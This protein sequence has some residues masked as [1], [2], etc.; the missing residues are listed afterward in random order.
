[1]IDGSGDVVTETASSYDLIVADYEARIDQAP[2]FRTEFRV[3][4]CRALPVAARVLDVGCGPGHDL[5]HF[6]SVGLQTVGL[7]ASTGMVQRCLERGLLAVRGD[8]RR[9][10]VAPRSVNGIWSSASLLHVPRDEVPAVLSAWHTT[11]T[12]GGVLGLSTSM[13]SDQGWECVPYQPGS[14]HLGKPLRRWF[15]HHEQAEL[16]QLLTEAGF[17]IQHSSVNT[18]HRRWLKVLCTRS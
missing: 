3:Q 7:D 14:Q 6:T 15:V 9:P 16:E 13:G 17:T 10:P 5:A 12:P 18:T 2:T 4:F 11:L 8:L 1:M